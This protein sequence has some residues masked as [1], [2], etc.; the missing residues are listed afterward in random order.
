MI[1]NNFHDWWFSEKYGFETNQYTE[2]GR[3]IS[4]S[5]FIEL[6]VEEYGENLN[7]LST[8]T[9]D[10][11]VVGFAK[12]SY[13]T[14]LDSGRS[15]GSIIASKDI[16]DNLMCEFIESHIGVFREVWINEGVS[17]SFRIYWDNIF[18]YGGMELRQ[19]IL[20]QEE[21]ALKFRELMALFCESPKHNL[22]LK[23]VGFMS[24]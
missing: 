4:D 7:W 5:R 11:Q 8:V 16:G 6:L 2:N 1:K 19:F 18:M 3:E 15:L 24:K 17:D 20:S 21:S 13:V 14:S 12:I 9:S 10:M 22:I 23:S